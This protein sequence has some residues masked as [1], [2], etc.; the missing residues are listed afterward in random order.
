MQVV[1]VEDECTEAEILEKYLDKFAE[2]NNLQISHSR[3][4]N[5]KEMLEKYQFTWDL[6]LLDIEMPLMN[7]IE[8]ARKIREKDS[9]VTI[10]FITQMAQYAIEG[11]SVNALDYVL[12][13]VNY[14]MFAMKMRRAVHE[15][16]MK[17]TDFILLQKKSQKYKI[18]LKT[19]CYIEV[20]GHTIVYHTLEQEIS[21]T[22]SQTIKQIER[23]LADKGF[24]RCHQCFLVNLNHVK[25]Y[26]KE[27][28][29][30]GEKRIPVS[31]S[32]RKEFLQA[33]MKYWG[34]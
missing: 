27:D 6:I 16:H 20:Y 24:I 29:Q 25:Q 13:P 15:F 31:R 4:S 5:G 23:E 18:P 8:I 17:Q 11:Y 14:N 12:K 10:I 32:R 28:I 7:G 30:V 3:F 19:L 33:L 1:I 22:G 34:G 2:E 21:M 9:E 26:N